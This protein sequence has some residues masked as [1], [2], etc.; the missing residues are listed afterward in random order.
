MIVGIGFSLG[1]YPLWTIGV[2][3]GRRGLLKCLI[4]DRHGAIGAAYKRWNTA[5]LMFG[6]LAIPG[7]II[8][9]ITGVIVAILTRAARR[10]ESLQIDTQAMGPT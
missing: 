9:G 8:A 7:V 5:V 10:R 6:T 1:S 4:K 3:R 2:S